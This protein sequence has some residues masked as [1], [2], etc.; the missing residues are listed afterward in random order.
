MIA[1]PELTVTSRSGWQRLMALAARNT[2]LDFRCAMLCPNHYKS[3]QISKLT[4]GA[5]YKAPYS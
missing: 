1:A 2:C 4:G 5:K 3:G